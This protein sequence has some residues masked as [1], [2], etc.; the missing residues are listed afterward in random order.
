MLPLLEIKTF[1]CG[2]AF[3]FS[4]FSKATRSLNMQAQ[5]K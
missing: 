2:F 3:L 4:F 5:I 1:L